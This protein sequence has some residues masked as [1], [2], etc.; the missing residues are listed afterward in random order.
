MLLYLLILR[1]NKMKAEK[2]TKIE[3]LYEVNERVQQIVNVSMLRDGVFA[4]VIGI[5]R[6][7]LSYIINKRY[8]VGMNVIL[9]IADTF[10]FIDMNWLIAGRGTV[11]TNPSDNVSDVIKRFQGVINN[12]PK[13]D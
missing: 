7:T 5:Q 9:N 6:Q 2:A 13:K 8:G 12:S 3:R 10:P 4:D 1:L 11:T